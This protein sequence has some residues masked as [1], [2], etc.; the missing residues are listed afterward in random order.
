MRVLLS[1]LIAVGLGTIAGTLSALAAAGLLPGSSGWR[2]ARVSVGGWTA[3]Y[4]IGTQQT[5]PWTRARVARDGLLALAQTEA[6][7]FTTTSD[8]EGR[9]L[10]EACAYRMTGQDQEALWWSIT[11]YDSKS[12]LPMN[13]DGRLSFD[14]TRAG[15]GSGWSVP[16][17]PDPPPAGPW[18]SSRNAGEFDLTLRLYRPSSAV[19]SD[20]QQAVRP[21]VIARVSCRGASAA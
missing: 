19:L 17:Q 9:R 1:L 4:T 13:E 8:S 7:Y 20:P 14:R 15:A 16:I 2:Q 6:V 10:S 12:R 21:P 11:L 18:I 3:D 5:D